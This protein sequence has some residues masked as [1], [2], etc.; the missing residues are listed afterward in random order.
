MR[1]TF[2]S[3]CECGKRNL[4]RTAKI[5]LI[6]KGIKIPP[7]FF[8]SIIGNVGSKFLVEFL[9]ALIN[10]GETYSIILDYECPWDSRPFVVRWCNDSKVLVTSSSDF[11]FTSQNIPQSIYSRWERHGRS[12][13]TTRLFKKTRNVWRPSIPENAPFRSLSESISRNV[14]FT[15]SLI[16]MHRNWN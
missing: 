5:R 2:N 14:F 10:L 9:T 15:H 3:L 13:R 6:R 4:E 7:P 12:L 16:P 1:M 8:F 11:Q